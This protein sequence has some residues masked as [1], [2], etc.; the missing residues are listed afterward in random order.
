VAQP[1]SAGS[2]FA[3]HNNVGMFSASLEAAKV[4]RA[5]FEEYVRG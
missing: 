1:G 2:S 3:Y 5:V 4:P